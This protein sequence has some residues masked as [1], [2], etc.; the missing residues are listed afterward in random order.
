M[1][2]KLA[3]T[4][5]LI[6][7]SGL[8]GYYV[9]SLQPENNNEQAIVQCPTLPV[10]KYNDMIW[11]PPGEFLMGSNN[12][13]PEEAPIVRRQVDGFWMSKY[14]VTNAQFAE[15]VNATGYITDAEKPLDA[16]A[17]PNLPA[18]MLHA[19]SVVFVMP[20]DLQ[21]GGS[22]TQWWQFVPGANWQSPLGPGSDIK[23]KQY[24]PV[25]HISHTDA[26]AYA[27]WRG[28][29]LPTE[30]QW[31]YA[32]SIGSKNKQHSQLLKRDQ[33][34]QANIWQGVFPI[35]NLA[36]DGHSSTAPVGCFT[37]NSAGLHD[38]IGN[39]WEWTSDWYYPNHTE[40]DNSEFANGYDPR[41]PGV[42][43]KVI[44]GGSYLCADNY[45]QRYRPAARHAQE[46]GLGA[47][48]IGF[49]TVRTQR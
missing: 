1:K 35:N 14:E 45:C 34:W 29:A 37:A 8:L 12:T 22:I 24:H 7:F 11:V 42:E 36:E 13:Y 10:N 15:F 28:H 38:M 18:E 48:H 33:I 20:T 44:K 47:A 3:L 43:V 39:V 32:A 26:L 16:K 40:D 30:S 9:T 6:L 5:C 4:I 27:Q 49:R 41:Q 25:V 17:F 2:N 21:A 19:G 23:D 46:T 31:E